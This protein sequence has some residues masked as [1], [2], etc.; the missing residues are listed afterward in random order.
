[1]SVC[2][3]DSPAR[4]PGERSALREMSRSHRVQGASTVLDRATL[5]S[6]QDLD[7]PVDPKLALGS[8]LCLA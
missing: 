5:N 3:A 1:M 4:A 2:C 6:A 8:R 7:S